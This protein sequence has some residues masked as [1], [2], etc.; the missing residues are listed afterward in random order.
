MSKAFTKDDDDAGF[1]AP[2]S[3]APLAIPSGPLLLTATGARRLAS[4]D[5]ARAALARAEVLPLVSSPDRAALGVTVHVRD[6]GTEARSYR[7]VTPAERALLGDG[8][9]I[10]SP[11]GRAL[12]GARVGDVR[13]AVAPRGVTELE[14][15]ALEGEVP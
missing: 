4:V 11:L 7:L 12:L 8:C 6:A 1:S 15:V 2:P 14:I 10:Q 3:A 9:S 5:E 13:E